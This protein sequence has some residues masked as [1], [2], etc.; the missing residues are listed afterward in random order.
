MLSISMPLFLL[1]LLGGA[2]LGLACLI[3]GHGV[4]R[5]GRV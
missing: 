1:G 4:W 5:L 3:V 2:K